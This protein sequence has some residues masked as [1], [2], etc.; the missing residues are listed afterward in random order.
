MKT[1][2]FECVKMKR[3][4]SRAVH[5][6]MKDMTPKQELA[7]WRRRGEELDERILRARRSKRAARAAGADAVRRNQ[8]LG[9]K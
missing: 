1:K 7:Y 4:G 3:R 5:E 2:T 6:R 8:G 9:R